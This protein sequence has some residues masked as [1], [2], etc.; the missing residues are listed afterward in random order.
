[1]DNDQPRRPTQVCVMVEMFMTS[2]PLRSPNQRHAVSA[3]Q[4]A[5]QPLTTIAW[6]QRR[7]HAT[8]ERRG[9]SRRHNP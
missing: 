5:R 6:L 4:M 9:Q 2:A 7:A 1:M 3:G 8:L